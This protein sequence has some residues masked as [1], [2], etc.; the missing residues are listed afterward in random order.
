MGPF[1]L[2]RERR[3]FSL[4][5]SPSRISFVMTLTCIFFVILTLLPLEST[6][7]FKDQAGKWDWRQSYVGRAKFLE[8]DATQSGVKRIYVATHDNAVASINARLASF[9][10]FVVLGGLRLDGVGLSSSFYW[11]GLGLM[12][13]A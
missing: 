9:A 12:V 2:D 11:V 5:S 6:A 4:P 3:T 10:A 7:L 8:T 1:I 13:G